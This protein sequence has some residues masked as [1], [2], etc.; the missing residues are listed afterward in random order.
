[1]N[2]AC[3]AS[4]RAFS[5]TSRT[6][7]SRSHSASC[8]AGRPEATSSGSGKQRQMDTFRRAGRFRRVAPDFFGGE[9][10]QRRHQSRP[11]RSGLRYSAV[12]PLL[13]RA[14]SRSPPYRD[15]PSE[16]RNTRAQIG[17]GEIVDRA[18]DL[19]ELERRRTSRGSAGSGP[20][21]APGSSDRFRAS[22]HR[23]GV[24]LGI[25]IVQVPERVPE[26]VAQLAIRLD[27]AIQD[28]VRQPHV[29][30]EI[31]RGDPQAQQS[32]PYC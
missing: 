31:N 13:R 14:G 20:R 24:L 25:E 18:I 10:E 8:A 28:R 32:A 9:R 6:S 11:T 23:H 7:I 3:R 12:W 4:S 30:G 1:M 17:R 21:F 22:P 16:C 19:V 15:G 2:F 29:F 26:R 5:T 27:Q